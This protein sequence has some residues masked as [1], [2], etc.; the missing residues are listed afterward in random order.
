M[1]ARTL[2]WMVAVLAALAAA[3]A[4][5]DEGKVIAAVG[6]VSAVREGKELALARGA[7]VK[8]GD[9]VKVAADSSA[10]IRM[11][12]ESILAL[13]PRTEFLISDYRFSA[14]KPTE[15]RAIFSLLKGAFR[16][17]TGIIGLRA[18]ENYRVN[19]VVATIGIRGTHYRL[20]LCAADCPAREGAA[21]KDGLYGGVSE[22]RIAVTNQTGTDEF[23]ADE[24]FFLADALGRPER[25]PGPPELLIDRLNFL[26]KLKREGAPAAAPAIAVTAPALA[27]SGPAL[28]ALDSLS[29]LSLQQFR[30]TE[31]SGSAEQIVH[32]TPLPVVTGSFVDVGASGDI[33]GQIIWMTNA[34]IDLHLQAPN[35]AH[36]YYG[37]RTA[38]LGTSTT[39]QLDIDNLGNTINVAPDQRIENLVVS[40]S[41]KPTGL[42]NFYAHS[43]S[44]NNGGLP[45]TVQIR[46]TGDG[47]STSLTDS[48]SLSNGQQSNSYIVDYKGSQQAPVYTTQPR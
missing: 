14:D 25:L 6:Q 8:S 4:A 36:V 26:S 31:I 39:A 10:Q 19:A 38:T 27:P 16:T 33:R 3:P 47:G 37:N 21:A 35:A 30:P 44:G 20:R 12:D 11:S 45:T 42:Y 5:A 24:Y 15:G 2:G 13:A 28:S 1:I 32:V 34:D 9:L 7:V 17:V 22:G 43:F 41:Q 23:G 18:R 48:V 40:G 46:V 29:T